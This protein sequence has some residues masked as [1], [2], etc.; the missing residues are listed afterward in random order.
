MAELKPFRGL[1]YPAA[2]SAEL[3]SLLAPPY[4]VISATQRQKLADSSPDNFVRLILPQEDET[5]SS[6]AAGA[7]TL[8][9][10]FRTRSKPR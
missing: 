6:Y 3:A 4:D 2:R 9:N 8:R 5:G 7:A 10:W 1:R